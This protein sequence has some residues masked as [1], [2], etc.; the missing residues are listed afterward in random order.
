[1]TP[2]N[3]AEE[4]SVQ[5]LPDD[6][7]AYEQARGREDEQ[8][9]TSEAAEPEEDDA[10]PEHDPDS[11][12]EID[13][14]EQDDEDE[15][16]LKGRRLQK[17]FSQL[18][19]E[20]RD[21]RA[22]LAK[23]QSGD[24]S[25]GQ[26]QKEPQQVEQNDGGKPDPLKYQTQE[27]YLEALTDWKVDQREQLREMQRVQ[28]ERSTAY[29]DRVT[30]LKKK[31]EY[32]DWDAVFSAVKANDIPLSPPFAEAL[33][34]DPNAAEVSYWLAKNLKQAKRIMS[35]PPAQGIRELGKISAKFDAPA[36]QKP[37]VSKAPA[38]ARPVAAAKSV[39][40]EKSLLDET[41]FSAYEKRRMQQLRRR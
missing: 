36:A 39:Q 32:A 29:N 13:E 23:R 14:Q 33:T 10:Q 21:L 15:A 38:P 12:P 16:P 4:T 27:E 26:Q 17:R 34:S 19:T 1:M 9:D 20:I 5:S 18:T 37:P 28:Q 35:L 7:D 31:P 2:M 6:F 8:V 40:G 30:E 41:D 22:E 3:G 25:P 11:D 24:A